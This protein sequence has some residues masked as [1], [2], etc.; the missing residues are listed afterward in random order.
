MPSLMEDEELEWEADHSGVIHIK[1]FRSQTQFLPG[2]GTENF[3][4]SPFEEKK[5]SLMKNIL[6][7]TLAVGALMA[8]KNRSSIAPRVRT[9]GDFALI[10]RESLRKVAA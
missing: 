10:F 7:S 2:Y 9:L 3:G 8:L 6:W 4:V 5:G 1:K